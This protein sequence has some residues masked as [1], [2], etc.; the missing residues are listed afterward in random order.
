MNFKKFAVIAV[1]LF[2]VLCPYSA[3]ASDS[4]IIILPPSPEYVKWLESLEQQEKEIST[5]SEADSFKGGVIP[6]PIDRSNLWKNPPRPRYGEISTLNTLPDY[7]DLREQNRL[8]PVKNQNP[9]GTCWAHA[10]LASMESTFKT[11]HSDSVLDLSEMFVAYFVYGDTRPGKSFSLNYENQN[12]LDQ[13][14]NS[15]KVIA[16][17][18]RLGCVRESILPYPSRQYTYTDPDKF[19]EEYPTLPVRLKDSYSIGD[20]IGDKIMNVVK[21]L[22]IKYGALSI[23]YY[24]NND[25][26]STHLVD[27]EYITTYF[28]NDDDYLGNHAV[29]IVGWDDNFSRMNFPVSMRPTKDGAW[30]VRNSWG[31]DWGDDGYFWMSYEQEIFDV[32][33]L[34]LD[35]APEGLK[36]YEMVSKYLQDRIR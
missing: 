15:D 16:L 12:I 4:D 2:R 8:T 31:T 30:L 17:T 7:Y 20:L 22:V 19:P 23:S 9:W 24:H 11:L 1:L 34:I 14:G 25:N 18:S 3:F 21:D 26:A 35:D 27:G 13:G 6:S 32:N 33:L 10:S 28:T 29:N 36:H 5:K